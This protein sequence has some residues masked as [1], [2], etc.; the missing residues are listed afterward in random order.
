M[1]SLILFHSSSSRSTSLSPAHVS[2]RTEVYPEPRSIYPAKT[3]LPSYLRHHH[4]AIL[5]S[6]QIPLHNINPHFGGTKGVQKASARF[7]R[8]T[9]FKPFCDPTHPTFPQVYF[10]P[11]LPPQL[12]TTESCIIPI[13]IGQS[14]A[15][16]L[17]YLP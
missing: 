4:P 2:S 17:P 5:K 10:V 9:P 6:E 7:A 3:Y 13:W 8:G 15:Y 1:Y 12:D 14:S 16:H 11:Y